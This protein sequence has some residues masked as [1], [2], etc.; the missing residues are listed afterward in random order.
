MWHRRVPL[1]VGLSAAMVVAFQA[2]LAGPAMA[3]PRP[4]IAE[5]KAKL[6]KLED[7]ADLA[8]ERY[9]EAN[10]RWKK[11]RKK[12]QELNADLK[13]RQERVD[14][15]RA[16]IRSLVAT[17]YSEGD[18]GIAGITGAGDPQRALS[19]IATLTQLS[20]ARAEALKGFEQAV[21]ELE[22]R[23]D[24]AKKAMKEAEEDREDFRR[25]KIEVEKLVREQERLLRRLGTYKTGDPNS[26]GMRYTGPA[27][28]NARVALQFAFAQIGKPYRY[29]GTGP[30]AWDCSGLTQAAWRAAGV[31][32]PRTTTQQ[33][34]WGASR[35]VPL[36]ALQPGDLVFSRSLGHVGLYIGGGKMVH[37]PRTGD[38]VKI[39]TLSAYGMH[40]LLG[41]VRP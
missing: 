29:G 25:K 21:K 17:A 5:A 26:A 33:W 37:A 4:T 35:R 12:Y 41:G 18:I 19:G 39:T 24:E 30:G 32:L 10:E 40:R 13:E 27:S 16:D 7:K 38:V 28:G 23:R 11:T 36:D 2:G 20:A 1:A 15:M 8:V 6:K 22:Q 34:A 9:N 31:E 3:E 14:R